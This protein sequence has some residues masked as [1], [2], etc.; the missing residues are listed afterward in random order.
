MKPCAIHSR[1]RYFTI[2]NNNGAPRIVAFYERQNAM[3]FQN[4]LVTHRAFKG[5]WPVVDA[6]GIYKKKSYITDTK[7]NVAN[8]NK[9]ISIEPLDENIYQHL[10]VNIALCHHFAFN[11]NNE[12]ITF[13]ATE[14]IHKKE[15]LDEYRER[16]ELLY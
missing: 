13:Q 12:A 4:F 10:N 14:Y 3:E 2:K 11:L 1:R 9:L 7:V 6:S 8:I 15:H 5:Y 16:L